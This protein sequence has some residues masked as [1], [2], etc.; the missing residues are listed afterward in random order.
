MHQASFCRKW[1]AY[2]K[3]LR[4]IFENIRLYSFT[5]MCRFLNRRML[6]C[7]W[8]R[9]YNSVV[10]VSDSTKRSRLVVLRSNLKF[11][12]ITLIIQKSQSLSEECKDHLV[13]ISFIKSVNRSCFHEFEVAEIRYRTIWSSKHLCGFDQ[14]YWFDII[15]PY[16]HK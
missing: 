9:F 13:R 16:N 8:H 14:V 12:S 11:L 6:H 1:L 7:I 4:A 2:R 3:L 10:P 15:C 5:I